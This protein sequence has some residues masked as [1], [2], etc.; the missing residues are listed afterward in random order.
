MQVPWRVL[1][2]V[3][4]TGSVLPSG[5]GSVLICLRV[6][7]EKY[8]PVLRLMT[9]PVAEA[10]E[11]LARCAEDSLASRLKSVAVPKLISLS[12]TLIGVSLPVRT[13]RMARRSRSMWYST[14]KSPFRVG[15]S[16]VP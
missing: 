16:S 15:S 3:V 7:I 11:S 14:R 13:F 1:P 6:A 2:L 8:L 12:S 10:T 4:T 5:G 9:T